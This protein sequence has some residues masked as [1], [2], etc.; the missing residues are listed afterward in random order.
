ME[1][2]DIQKLVEISKLYYLQGM[3]QEQIA[4]IFGISRSAVSMYLT[5]AK[6][7]GIVQVQIKDPSENNE[8]LAERIER[9]FGIKKCIV[10]PSGTH[11]HK[12]MLRIVTS[13]AARFARDL[14]TSHSSLGIAWGSTCSE[15]MNA[16]PEDTD[17]C[18]I[19]VVPMVGTSL[20][21]TEEYQLNESIRMF[22]EKL[23]GYPLFIYS[24]GIVDTMDDYRRIMDSTY[25]KPILDRWKNMEYAV[26]GIG[27]LQER[28]VARQLR[29][30]GENM[31][32]EI[33]RYHDMAV[34]DICARWFNI[35]GEFIECEHNNKLIGAD[36]EILGTIKNVMAIAIGSSK[37]FAIIGGLRTGV[38]HYFVTD[39]NTARQVLAVMES[40]ALPG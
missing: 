17:L 5:D 31:L 7:N 3:T 19:S 30:G 39:E 32:E 2:S 28:D 18:D 14:F 26:L 23:R 4:K 21:L 29:C 6:N 35:R 36:A 34:G 10:V 9:E 38:I 1:N 11:N 20:L 40:N 37:V 25:M 15:F 33:S 16:F 13:Q 22:A 12:V 24:P 27:R 8:E